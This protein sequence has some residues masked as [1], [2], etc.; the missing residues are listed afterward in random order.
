[1]SN[2]MG[3]FTQVG[4]V[5]IGENKALIISETKEQKI[6]IAQ[7]LTFSNDDGK[8][9]KIFMKNAIVV[10]YEELEEIYKTIGQ[11]LEKNKK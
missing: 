5:T 6:A 3:R 10:S 1:M 4:K 8:T 7:Q 11:V 9:V 2:N